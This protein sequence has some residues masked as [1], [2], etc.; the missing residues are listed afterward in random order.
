[1]L[2]SLNLSVLSSNNFYVTSSFPRGRGATSETG[3]HPFT[4]IAVT[5][6]A[7]L[8]Y[9]LSHHTDHP[10]DTVVKTVRYRLCRPPPLSALE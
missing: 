4:V 7:P 5:I 10:L 6:M 9:F 2:C 8:S 1:M 3:L